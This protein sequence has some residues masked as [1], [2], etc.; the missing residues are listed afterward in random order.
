MNLLID[1]LPTSVIIQ[2]QE[3][4][5]NSKFYISILF[6]LL[7]QK[8]A[9]TNE[10]KVSQALSLYFP[11]I[12]SDIKGAI[13]A[14]LW[15]YKCGNEP[16]DKSDA[17]S[18]KGHAKQSYCF[19]QDAELIYSAFFNAYKI[20]LAE[21]DLHWWKFRALFAGLPSECEIKKIMG[22]RTADLKGLSK[23]QKKMYEKMR[24]LYALKSPQSVESVISLSVRNQR[25]KDYIDRRFREIKQK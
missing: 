23:T 16:E 12:P 7:M 6:E 20:D 13:D 9:V 24:K 14:M 1:P 22:Y 11:E 18:G 15:F 17:S 10:E 2:G 19:E 4:P 8:D 5:I 21:V 3:W 25:M